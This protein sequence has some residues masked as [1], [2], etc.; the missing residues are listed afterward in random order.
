LAQ[1]VDIYIYPAGF[2]QWNNWA[3]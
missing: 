2:P 1:D 3:L